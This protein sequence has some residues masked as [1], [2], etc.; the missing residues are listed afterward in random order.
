MTALLGPNGAGKTT[1]VRILSTLLRPDA[2]TARVGG[3]DV[4]REPERVQARIGLTGQS[5]SVDGKLSGPENLD[6]AH[7]AAAVGL[8]EPAASPPPGRPAITGKWPS[9]ASGTSATTPSS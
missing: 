2:G 3:Y 4:A 9:A 7:L 6:A 1:M 5:L 8:P